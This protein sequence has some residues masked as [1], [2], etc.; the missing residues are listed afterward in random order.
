MSSLLGIDLGTSSVKAVVF[1]VE[2]R[3]EGC[4]NGGVSDSYA[5]SRI[6]GT[7]SRAVVAG[8]DNCY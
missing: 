1:A 5:A 3:I 7:G 8:D 4:W 6:C 2:G